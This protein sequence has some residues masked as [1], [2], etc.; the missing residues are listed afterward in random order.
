M[1]PE[2]PLFPPKGRGGFSFLPLCH[3]PAWPGLFIFSHPGKSAEFSSPVSR[4]LP[5]LWCSPRWVLGV[6]SLFQIP[7]SPSPA[8]KVHWEGR[9]CPQGPISLL[10][11]ELTKEFPAA[12]AISISCQLF[13]LFQKETNLKVSPK[14]PKCANLTITL[15][16]S[17]VGT[18]QPPPSTST[19]NLRFI[20]LPFPS[21]FFFLLANLL[22][23][24]WRSR[25]WAWD[26]PFELGVVEIKTFPVESFV[27]SR[28]MN[29][30]GTN[31]S[32]ADFNLFP[33]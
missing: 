17:L 10:P 31:L 13:G 23:G 4:F 18:S 19:V 25:P 26:K 32:Q 5:G 29:G 11:P 22:C 33:V 24:V 28:N 15:R 30:N 9:E 12:E 8:G 27:S 21:F 3:T 6:R 16:S 1:L 2:F 14:C 20:L 7:K